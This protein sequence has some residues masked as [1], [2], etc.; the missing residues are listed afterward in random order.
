M[1]HERDDAREPNRGDGNG[2][3]A[4]VEG[5]SEET[6][7]S[8]DGH[9]GFVLLVINSQ[10]RL[11]A[12]ILSLVLDKERARDILQ[13][14]NLV[15]L[16]KE[17]GFTHGT[18]F[19]AWAARVA[20]YEVLADRRRRVRDRHLFSDELLAV[21]ASESLKAA[22][23]IEER[24]EA[25]R[26]CLSKLSSKNRDLLM[27]R[28]RPEGSVADIAESLGKTPGAVSA[29]LHRLRAGLV[30]CVERRLRSQSR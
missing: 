26:H 2:D 6:G 28:Y 16:E 9:E 19:F 11:Y 30:D 23:A 13:Q 3:D 15:L 1:S 5:P 29:L 12:Y 14:T 25:L 17:S 8:G 27:K 18:D 24:A 22:G 20:Y 4:G 7:G 21:V 10:N